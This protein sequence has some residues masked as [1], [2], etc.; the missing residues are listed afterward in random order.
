MIEQHLPAEGTADRQG[1]F[2]CKARDRLDC[3]FIPARPTQD[4]ERPCCALKKIG[5]LFDT[6]RRWPRLDRLPALS[7]RCFDLVGQHVFRQ[8][9]HDRPRTA[10]GRD[11]KC[12]RDE[13]RNAPRI[14]DL[15]HPFGC[16]AKEAPVV[17]FL[18]G[19]ALTCVALHLANE[20]DQR[21]RILHGDVD[22]GGGIGGAGAA[23]DKADAW[24][25]GQLSRGIGHHRG[26]ALGPANDDAYLCVVKRVE[27]GKI[28]FARHAK[29]ALDAIGLERLDDQLSAGFHWIR[30]P[31]LQEFRRCARQA[32]AR[33]VH[34]Q[35][36][37]STS[38]SARA[39]RAKC[40]HGR[41]RDRAAMPRRRSA[42]R[43]TSRRS[44]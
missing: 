16:I 27:H 40:C 7:R 19:F 22:A 5:E 33:A 32:A 17:D 36:G 35:A 39:P 6:G 21:R 41:R 30:P 18:K 9:Q 11:G 34:R 13:F 14:V 37:F 24:L 20:Q 44:C 23:R 2:F 1:P 4:H 38:P 43:R 10:R 25:A 12:A 29:Q 15:G 26:A 31:V 3:V 8:R 42:D 28:A